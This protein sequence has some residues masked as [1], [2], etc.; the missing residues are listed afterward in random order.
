LCIPQG[1]SSHDI[2]GIPWTKE[3]A[4]LAVAKMKTI[5]MFWQIKG[6]KKN[7]MMAS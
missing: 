6:K 2:L 3:L 7:E 5:D 4:V 1:E